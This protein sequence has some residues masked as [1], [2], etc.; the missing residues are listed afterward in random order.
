VLCL[1]C[2]IGVCFYLTRAQRNGPAADLG[3]L[4]SDGLRRPGAP[5]CLAVVGDHVEAKRLTRLV[6]RARWPGSIR[7][8]AKSTSTERIRVL[9]LEELANVPMSQPVLVVHDSIELYSDWDVELLALSTENAVWSLGASESLSTLICREFHCRRIINPR[10]FFTRASSRVAAL[11][12]L[13]YDDSHFGLLAT[14]LLSLP[15]LEFPAP[16]GFDSTG[17]SPLSQGSAQTMLTLRLLEVF[18]SP[19]FTE[20][21]QKRLQNLFKTKLRWH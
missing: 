19:D 4:A 3:T 5:V 12:K 2:F 7:L 13:W 8:F 16:P 11:L 14:V 6:S 9:A 21:D 15:V 17:P 18:M 1:I 10:C 20:Q